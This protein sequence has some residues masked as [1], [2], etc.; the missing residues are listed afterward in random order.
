MADR[1]QQV[2]HLTFRGADGSG[3]G[4]LL[5]G[6]LFN[7]TFDALPSGI[8]PSRVTTTI[9]TG[10]GNPFDAF[11]TNDATQTPLFLG[12]GSGSFVAV[13]TGDTYTLRVKSSN[14][15]SSVQAD[16]SLS[17]SFDTPVGA[18]TP[19]TPS[20]IHVIPGDGPYQPPAR[21]KRALSAGDLAFE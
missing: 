12:T 3:N 21:A 20:N 5:T 8:N 18:G 15:S 10:T 9:A 13:N 17:R 16:T 14:G 6:Y 2:A 4:T 19:P 1:T 7:V 11:D